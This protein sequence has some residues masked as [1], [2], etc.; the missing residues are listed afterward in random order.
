MHET[1][2]TTEYGQIIRLTMEKAARFMS[3]S[4]RFCVIVFSLLTPLHLF[5]GQSVCFTSYYKKGNTK[6]SQDIWRKHWRHRSYSGIPGM[7]STI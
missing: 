7:E 1:L 6:R 3:M 2:L 4:V 5:I